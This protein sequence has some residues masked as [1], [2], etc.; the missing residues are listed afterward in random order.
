VRQMPAPPARA[1]Q[2]LERPSRRRSQTPRSISDCTATADAATLSQLPCSGGSCV[3]IT[4]AQLL[5]AA[6]QHAI[7]LS[8]SIIESMSAVECVRAQHFVCS[9]SGAESGQCG[10][11]ALLVIAGEHGSSLMLNVCTPEEMQIFTAVLIHSRSAA[12]TRDT[13][14]RSCSRVLL[15]GQYQI[16]HCRVLLILVWTY[17]P[18]QHTLYRGLEMLASQLRQLIRYWIPSGMRHFGSSGMRCQAWSRL[19]QLAH[20]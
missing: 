17:I 10:V 8:G 12:A 16:Y 11:V 14:L 4:A 19:H 6:L 1:A 7:A 18:I 3:A 9:C 13:L 5:P 15:T 2:Q 20:M